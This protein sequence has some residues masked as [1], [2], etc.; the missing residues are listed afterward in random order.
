ML[1]ESDFAELAADMADIIT[2]HSQSIS[3]RRGSTTL[4]AQTVRVERS[5]GSFSRES[6]TGQSRATWGR[7]VIIGDSEMD[8]ALGDTFTL[9]GQ[10]YEVKFVRPNRQAFTQ[11][12]AMLAQ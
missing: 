9:D 4:S 8:V 5:G 1:E 10:L 7:I 12:E 6:T 3:F 2:D 11:A